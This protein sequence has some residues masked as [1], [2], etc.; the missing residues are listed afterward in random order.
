MSDKFMELTDEYVG[1]FMNQGG[2]DAIGSGRDKIASPAQFDAATATIK[3]HKLDGVIIIGGDDSNTNAALLAEHLVG[4]SVDCC[5]VGVP[6]TIDCDLSDSIEVSFGFDTAARV[7]A[8]LVGNVMDDAQSSN[9][10]YHFIR[11]MGRSASHITLEC[12]MQTRPNL[13]LISEEVGEQGLTLLDLGVALADL[14][15][16]RHAAG[17]KHGVVLVPEG[18]V[19]F[20]PEIA[21]LIGELNTLLAT[22]SPEEAVAKLPA[23]LRATYSALPEDVAASLLAERDSHGNVQVSKIET[24]RLLMLLCAKVLRERK[25]PAAASFQPVPMFLGYEGRSA[26]PTNFDCA[27]SYS[28]GRNA[29]ALI[30]CNATGYMSHLSGLTGSSSPE[31]WVAGGLPLISMMNM[32]KRKG[33]MVPV[34]E[35]ALVR[36]D[37]PLFARFAAERDSWRATNLYRPTGPIQFRGPSSFELPMKLGGAPPAL[38]GTRA[39]TAVVDAGDVDARVGVTVVADASSAA[40]AL[41]P[42]IEPYTH[43]PVR[44]GVVFCGRQ[45]AGAHNVLTGLL[46]TLKAH[47]PASELVGYRDGTDG[48]FAGKS[49]VLTRADLAPFRQAG[50]LHALRRSKDML[51]T[52]EQFAAAYARAEADGLH[53]LVLVGGSVTYRDAAS[54]AG[55]VAREHPESDLAVVTVPVSVDNLLSR[56]FADVSVGF[57]TATKVYSYLAGNILTDANSAK[58]YWFFLRTMGR[59]AG[60]MA[61]EVAM[62]TC[63]NLLILGEE[64][65]AQRWS[66]STLVSHVA[67]VIARRADAGQDYGIVVLPEGLAGDVLEL[68]S[69]LDEVAEQRKAG[70]GSSTAK[71]TLSPWNQ[72]LLD[73]LPAT[74]AEELLNAARSH[75]GEV[76]FS[77]IEMDKL[78]MELVGTEL[79]TRKAAGSYKGKYA[80]VPH[81]L[82]YVGR[83]AMPTSFDCVLGTAY[84]KAAGLLVARTPSGPLRRG[85]IAARVN[86]T[87][88][89]GETRPSTWRFG[90]LSLA[91]QSDEV[92]E[93][94]PVDLTSSAFAKVKAARDSWVLA[95][96]VRS[97]GPAQFDGARGLISDAP[98]S[99]ATSDSGR[100]ALQQRVL[101]GLDEVRSLLS[102]PGVSD[103]TL[104]IGASLVDHAAT[105]LRLH[106][107]ACT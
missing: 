104:E 23:K 54:F 18:L 32:E 52:P 19:E 85:G 61:L 73:S 84:G 51:R 65:A 20:V 58:K 82:G 99:I 80:P 70:G 31:S 35:K 1:A 98:M 90:G 89:A 41:R 4:A 79:A 105:V 81:F 91:A 30:R 102:A 71:L 47:H 97:P 100:Q 3:K 48:L 2:F 67:D 11:L 12:A 77:S 24:E 95:D 107:D 46:D 96:P 59:T 27:Y 28:L 64:V 22:L 7:Y 45:A 39:V 13:A 25:S 76:N 37:G 62:Q 10:Y 21:N 40:L 29:A 86:W 69:L 63:P 50:G 26:L 17:L 94:S 103:A 106:M 83:S 43:V 78:L 74:I 8:E 42:T 38:P 60:H 53:G 87:G 6:K 5:V 92:F 9:K 44:V 101:G 72:S 36:T 14:V 88:A 55:Y 33:K 66:L 93:P 75:A 49:V 56:R 68:R 34:I 57:D 16:E 15:E